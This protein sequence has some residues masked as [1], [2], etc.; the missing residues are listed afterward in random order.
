M[1]NLRS[2]KSVENDR[3]RRQ[4]TVNAAPI[5]PPKPKPL[6]NCYPS[7]CFGENHIKTETEYRQVE[8]LPNMHNS[9][10]NKN[11]RSLADLIDTTWKLNEA[12]RKIERKKRENGGCYE[13]V[14]KRVR[15]RMQF[16]MVSMSQNVL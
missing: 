13:F 12:P 15:G 16:P 10:L 14:S 1:S 4:S 11:P 3:K 5:V 9:I 6:S 7:I 2:Q 8:H